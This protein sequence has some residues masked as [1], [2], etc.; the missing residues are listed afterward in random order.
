[1]HIGA[2]PA[3]GMTLDCCMMMS[4]KA[5]MP[6]WSLMSFYDSIGKPDS[7]PETLWQQYK[8]GLQRCAE[9]MLRIEPQSRAPWMSDITWAHVQ[10]KQDS[11]K[12]LKNAE[13]E[14]EKSCLQQ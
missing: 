8:L 13:S 5:N 7:T 11:Y 1:M 3:V 2:S 14:H 4:Y 12:A 9:A 6:A 10:S